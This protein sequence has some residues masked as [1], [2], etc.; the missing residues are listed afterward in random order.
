M[1]KPGKYS[2]PFQIL[3]PDYLLPS[4][5]WDHG[6]LNTAD[7][8]YY[9][10]AFYRK[11]KKSITKWKNFTTTTVLVHMYRKLPALIGYI[12][13]QP[14]KKDKKFTFLLTSGDVICNLKLSEQKKSAYFLHFDTIPIEL[15]IENRT[16]LKIKNVGITLI[17]RLYIRETSTNNKKGIPISDMII[18]S[19]SCQKENPDK[20]PIT[21]SDHIV[22]SNSMSLLNSKY[23]TPTVLKKFHTYSYIS[24]KIV[25][26]IQFVKKHLNVKFS[27]PVFILDPPFEHL[28]KA[29]KKRKLL[30]NNKSNNNNNNQEDSNDE[31]TNHL[32]VEE[33]DEELVEEEEEEEEYNNNE[34]TLITK[35]GNELILASSSDVDDDKGRNLIGQK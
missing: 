2:F 5:H 33:V 18:R 30:K 22:L 14:Y 7:R 9:L 21:K 23:I 26:K 29:L 6:K 12:K 8:R 11:N 15:T 31:D 4:F 35:D 25:V 17:Q 20:F 32:I 27:L 19:I 10:L 16:K 1:I 28:S 24:H 34:E 3:F 13:Q